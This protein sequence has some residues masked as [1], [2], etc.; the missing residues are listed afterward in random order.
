RAS[1][2]ACFP[3]SISSWA[4]NMSKPLEGFTRACEISRHPA[5]RKH[6]VNVHTTPDFPL[7]MFGLVFLDADFASPL[8]LLPRQ[9]EVDLDVDVGRHGFDSTPGRFEFPFF[10][11]F[12]R[13]LVHLVFGGLHDLYITDR[14]IGLD[15][16]SNGRGPHEAVLGRCCWILGIRPFHG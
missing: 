5:N 4:E 15:R 12:T 14:A 16:E 10:Y 6:A 8:R 11:S 2:A 13:L 7:I 3:A 9:A 1:A